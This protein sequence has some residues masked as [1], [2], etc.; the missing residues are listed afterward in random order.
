MP[1]YSHGDMGT[2]RRTLVDQPEEQRDHKLPVV[3]RLCVCA[4]VCVRGCCCCPVCVRACVRATWHPTTVCARARASAYARVC[5]CAC[6]SC[7]VRACGDSC[8]LSSNGTAV[9]VAAPRSWQCAPSSRCVFRLFAPVFRLF[10]PQ[11]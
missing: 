11:Y 2:L 10:V 5:A 7:R 4:R 8:D 9:I 1:G 6:V 3:Q